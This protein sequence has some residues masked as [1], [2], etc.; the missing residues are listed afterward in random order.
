MQ[1]RLAFA[2]VLAVSAGG[3]AGPSSAS[4]MYNAAIQLSAQGFGS[5]PRDLTVQHTGPG[6]SNDFESGCVGVALGGGIVVGPSGCRTSDAT[7]DPN[8]VVPIGGDEPSPQT[9]GNK[10]NTPTLSALGITSANQIGILFNATEPGGDDINVTDITLNFYGANG[11]FITSIDGQ[12]NFASSNPG[13][14]VAGFVFVVD[15]IEQAI[16]N[17][18]IFAQANVGSVILSLNASLTNATGGPD[19]FRIVNLGSPICTG[20]C[21]GPGGGGGVPEPHS[22]AVLVAALIA[23]STGLRRAARERRASRG[24]GNVGQRGA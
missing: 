2:F 16:L 24:A 5:A 8:G 4:L 23:L 11:T 19:T 22:L 3:L 18:L 7:V 9:D 21:G 15:P 20:N 17:T 6:V 14:G 1:R 12:Q 10:Y 13:N